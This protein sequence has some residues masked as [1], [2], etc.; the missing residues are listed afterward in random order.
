MSRHIRRARPLRRVRRASARPRLAAYGRL[1]P[2]P[3]DSRRNGRPNV[4]TSGRQAWLVCILDLGVVA[5]SAGADLPAPPAAFSRRIHFSTACARVRI[6]RGARVLIG[7]V[8]PAG[9]RRSRLAAAGADA[10]TAPRNSS[11]TRSINSAPPSWASSP[12][13]TCSQL[14]SSIANTPG[15][16]RGLEVLSRPPHCADRLHEPIPLRRAMRNGRE[17]R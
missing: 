13:L 1:D 8:R 12:T 11:T 5:V 9:L 15:A 7:S 10:D 17:D 16:P 2:R 6:L 14:L 4:R 3:A